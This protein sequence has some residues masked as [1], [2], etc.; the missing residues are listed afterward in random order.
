M[1]VAHLAC[2]LDSM[3]APAEQTTS[4]WLC[5]T[6]SLGSD[7]VPLSAPHLQLGPSI[8]SESLHS[9]KF[10]DWSEIRVDWPEVW[11]R[12]AFPWTKGRSCCLSLFMST[13]V[14]VFL[15]SCQHA[16]EGSFWMAHCTKQICFV[17]RNLINSSVQTPHFSVCL[18][19]CMKAPPGF[20]NQVKPQISPGHR[21]AAILAVVVWG[22][23]SSSG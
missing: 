14:S 17:K 20:V 10:W 5:M 18:K 23:S 16:C 2:L 8:P 12:P 21:F 1:S 4:A 7:L 6:S 19:V 11:S 22:C 3:S 9:G 15:P 13:C